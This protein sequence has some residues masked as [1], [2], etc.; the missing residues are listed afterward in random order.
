MSKEEIL[1]VMCGV[2]MRL[3]S[4][5][6]S[7]YRFEFSSDVVIFRINRYDIVAG[8]NRKR[9]DVLIPEMQLNLSQVEYELVAVVEHAGS[10]VNSGHYQ[11]IVRTDSGWE[12]RNDGILQSTSSEAAPLQLNGQDIYLVVYAKSIV[13]VAKKL[14]RVNAQALERA[15][16]NR[17]AEIEEQ[18]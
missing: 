18:Q 12:R 16:M 6:Q 15:E 9:R 4:S 3:A 1:E 10:T 5:A 17:I 2:C 14:A 11:A 8:Q 7:W 13:V